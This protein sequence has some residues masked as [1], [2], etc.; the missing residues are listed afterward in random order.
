MSTTSTSRL[1]ILTACFS[2]LFL[3]VGVHATETMVTFNGI[4][5]EVRYADCSSYSSS[6]SCQGWNNT[7]IQTTDFFPGTT[8]TLGEAFSG[9]FTYDSDAS[10]YL[11]SDGYQTS[12]LWATSASSFS[13]PN[14]ALPRGSLDA[15]AGHVSISDGRSGADGFRVSHDYT[16]SNFFIEVST[17]NYDP[18]GKAFSSHALPVSMD[19]STFASNRMSL[20]FLRSSDRD[21]V[22]V[23]GSIASFNLSPI[24]E[25]ST[26]SLSA[27][28]LL[29]FAFGMRRRFL[30]R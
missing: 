18:T 6:G 14:F 15:T 10:G 23:T 12:Y 16:N 29:A 19:G 5:G 2:A 20:V 11:S 24:A 8:I 22:W 4:V 21:Q 30:Q 27:L 25:P 3:S 13:T 17:F 26:A 1:S 7:Q 28:G 9:T